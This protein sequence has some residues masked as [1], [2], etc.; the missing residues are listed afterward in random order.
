MSENTIGAL[1]R[2]AE[3][4]F[5]TGYTQTSK[6]VQESL[7]DD[8]N[9]IEAYLNSKHT[10]GET[11]SLG[12]DK[13]FFNIV[14]AKK[15]ITARATDLDRKNIRAKAAKLKDQLASYLFTIHLQK[16]MSDT[17]FGAF[18]NLW[19]DYLAA[20]NSAVCKFVEQDGVMK[21]QVIPWN[22]IICDV[23]D[24]N[25][26]PVIEVLELTPAQLRKRKYDKEQVES[27]INALSARESLDKQKKDSKSNYIKLYEIHGEMPLSYLTGEED[28]EEDYVQQMHIVSFV[29]GKKTG[30]FDEFDLYKGRE[31]KNPYLLTW[32][33]PSVDGSISLMGSVKT[34]FEAQWMVNHNAKAIKDQLD[35]ASK[36]I[37]QI[38]DPNFTG[39]NVLSSIENGNISVYDPQK[40]PNGLRQVQ[41]NSHDITSLQNFGQQWQDLAQQLA[42]TPDIMGGENMPSGT[43]F[44]QAAIIQ[45]E[46]HGNFEKMTE[47]KG[48][49]VEQMF[50]EYIT[51]HILKKMDTTEEISATLDAYGI[52]KIDELYINNEAVR[53]FNSKAVEAVIN[54]TELPDLNQEMQGVKSELN[55]LGSQR[56]L[57]PSDIS[58]KT[59]KEVLGEFEGDIVYEI[60]GEN[61]DKQAVMT[62]LSTVF[63]TI[64]VNP[65]ILQDPNV[66]LIFNKILDETNAISPIEMAEVK[67]QPQPMIPANPVQGGQQVGAGMNNN[68]QM[69]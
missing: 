36:L 34:L 26:N 24:F 17:N 53:R 59:W 11:D 37:F 9:K 61:R 1:V 49:F 64:A 63:Q 52:D 65:M 40:D 22:R 48:L 5:T 57:K 39:Q 25:S 69:M 29:E 8:I 19:G 56:F 55:K 16:W 12:R 13:P 30:E 62:T 54:E 7:F 33:I 51:P 23:I 42:G 10:S 28:D 60:T 15:N 35:L 20:F 14:I 58:T 2:K 27:L 6:Y 50:R 31:K 47:N 46:A 38:G 45:Q 4:D 68:Q 18:L 3:S 66:R 32:L 21:S 44:R 67:A 43:A 41:N